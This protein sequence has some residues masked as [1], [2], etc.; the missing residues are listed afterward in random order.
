MLAAARVGLVMPRE[1]AAGRRTGFWQRG[2]AAERQPKMLVAVPTANVW[3]KTELL[4]QSLA[5]VSDPFQLLVGF[6]PRHG[7]SSIIYIKPGSLIKGWPPKHC[8][9][10]THVQ[11]SPDGHHVHNCPRSRQRSAAIG[12][13]QMKEQKFPPLSRKAL[14]G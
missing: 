4:L 2:G 6:A 13:P 8:L 11:T 14:R 9:T 10:L 1:A 12:L 3:D 5:A 7:Q